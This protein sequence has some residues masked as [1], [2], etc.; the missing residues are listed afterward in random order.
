MTCG[1]VYTSTRSGTKNVLAPW[2]AGL[3]VLAGDLASRAA[4]MEEQLGVSVYESN[5]VTIGW[6]CRVLLLL[7]DGSYQQPNHD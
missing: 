1:A 2:M 4:K 6:E 7:Q 3:N 5:G